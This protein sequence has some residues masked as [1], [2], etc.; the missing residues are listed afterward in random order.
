MRPD[1]NTAQQ[2][3]DA[4]NAPAMPMPDMMPDMGQAPTIQ[5]PAGA[6]PKTRQMAEEENIKLRAEFEGLK[7]AARQ[8][9]V[10][11]ELDKRLSDESMLPILNEMIKTNRQTLD[12]PFAELVNA[13]A[14]IMASDQANAMDS[15]KQDQLSLA[16]PLAKMLG[17][18]P[19]D[20]DFQA[21]LDQIINL[22]STKEGREQQLIKRR[23]RILRKM[24]KAP[25]QKQAPKSSGAVNYMEYFK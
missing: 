22:N 5:A 15:L 10:M 12:M 14:R 20:K 2:N 21:S 6:S 23:D 11:E 4:M 8:K 16:A 25:P 7:G 24:D 19:T 17:T 18:N 3:I 13:P 9:F 1:M